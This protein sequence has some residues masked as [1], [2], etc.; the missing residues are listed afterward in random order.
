M[1]IKH[2]PTYRVTLPRYSCRGDKWL[3]GAC[4]EIRSKGD[5]PQGASLLLAQ[6]GPPPPTLV[7]PASRVNVSNWHRADIKLRPLFGRY[8]VESGHHRLVMS[9]SAFDPTRTSAALANG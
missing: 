2:T 9:I 8:G 3:S 1:R 4:A 7:N 5:L 6:T